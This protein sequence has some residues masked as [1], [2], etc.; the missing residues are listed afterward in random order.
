M[1]MDINPY[2][3]FNGKCEAAFNFYAQCFD[4]ASPAFHKY[5]GSPMA[6]HVGPDWQDKVMHASMM[7][8]DRTLMGADAPPQQFTQP[9][10]F[11]VSINMNSPQDAERIFNAL[12]KGGKVQMPIQQTFWAARFGMLID[13]FGIPWMVNCGEPQ[14]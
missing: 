12:A 14:G 9:A 10:G 7:I 6:E 11:A 3:S 2:L 5:G 1:K 13:Q 8:G 4:V